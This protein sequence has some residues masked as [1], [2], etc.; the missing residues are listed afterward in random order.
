M[1]Y[2][3]SRVIST[4][5][6]IDQRIDQSHRLPHQPA[7]NVSPALSSRRRRYAPSQRVRNR[8]LHVRASGELLTLLAGLGGKLWFGGP[9]GPAAGGRGPVALMR[10]QAVVEAS[11]GHT[12]R[13]GFVTHTLQLVA[14]GDALT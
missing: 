5:T 2:S 11:C 14:H 9:T 1:N 6:M 12:L 3:A 10:W 7:V 13:G 4:V 8:L